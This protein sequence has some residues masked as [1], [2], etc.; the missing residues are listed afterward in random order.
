MRHQPVAWQEAKGANFLLDQF[1]NEMVGYH[2][3][4]SASAKTF[5]E[6]ILGVVDTLQFGKRKIGTPS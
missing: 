6:L 4:T 2:H 1:R 3:P 5:L